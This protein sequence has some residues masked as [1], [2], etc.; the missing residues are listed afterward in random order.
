[1]THEQIARGHI[2]L[3]R[4]LASRPAKRLNEFGDWQIDALIALDSAGRLIE[5]RE[6]VWYATVGDDRRP[7]GRSEPR[8][9]EWDGW[10]STDQGPRREGWWGEQIKR[11]REA[12]TVALEVRLSDYGKSVLALV[13]QEKRA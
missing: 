11:A 8:P 2:A 10:T 9:D 1:M 4:E 7:T 13:L 6:W 3:M 5:T 12:R